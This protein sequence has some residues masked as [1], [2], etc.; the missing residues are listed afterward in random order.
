MI[1][2]TQAKMEALGI[3]CEQVDIGM[4]TLPDDSLL[5]L[6]NVLMAKLG[7]VSCNLNS[8][9]SHYLFVAYNYSP[10]IHSIYSLLS[11]S[12]SFEL[13]LARVTFR[14][15]IVS[16]FHAEFKLFIIIHRI[17]YTHAQ[18]H[19]HTHALPPLAFAMFEKTLEKLFS[20]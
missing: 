8:E 6:P 4:Q 14:Y 5:K 2:W 15:L 20:A 18:R 10:F 17:S 1:N 19:T 13:T 3:V 11:V 7:N 16:E 9:I 12:L